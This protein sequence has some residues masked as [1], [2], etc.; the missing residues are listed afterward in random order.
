MFSGYSYSIVSHSQTK[1][2]ATAE[3]ARDTNDVKR[4]F[5]VIQGHPLLCQ[6]T[7]YIYDFLLAFNSNLTSSFNRS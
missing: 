2:S 5:K 4:L 1:S 3:I 6:P 7:R